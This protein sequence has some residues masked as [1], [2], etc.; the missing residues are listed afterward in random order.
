[1][2]EHSE[3]IVQLAKGTI[4]NYTS[5][6]VELLIF[7]EIIFESQMSHHLADLVKHAM[8]FHITNQTAP[9]IQ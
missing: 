5:C 7:Y 1:L 6:A 8:I 9:D 2:A 4:K 3:K